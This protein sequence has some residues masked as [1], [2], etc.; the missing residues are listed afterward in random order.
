MKFNVKDR[1]FLKVNGVKVQGI[2]QAILG[3]GKG[4]YQYE[5]SIKVKYTPFKGLT[6]IAF[7]RNEDEIQLVNPKKRD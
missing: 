5:I 7:I 4:E 2:I 6:D 1:V 3:N